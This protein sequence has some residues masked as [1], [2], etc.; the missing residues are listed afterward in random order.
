MYD[1]ETGLYYLHARY[2]DPSI[3]WFINEDTVEGQIDNPLSQN[4][5]TYVSNN[6]LIYTDPTGHRIAEDNY[7]SKA[8]QKLIDTYTA[9][10]NKAKAAGNTAAMQAAHDKAIA[11]RVAN[12]AEVIAITNYST[13]KL[14]PFLHT[15]EDLMRTILHKPLLFLL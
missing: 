12:G 15:T 14:H 5:Y 4:L 9:D 11:I 7:W 8:D 10:F 3:G 2:Y 13:G 6:P 1:A